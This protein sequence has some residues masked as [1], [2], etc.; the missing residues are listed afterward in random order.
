M[1]VLK[2]NV[3]IISEISQWGREGDVDY[4][5]KLTELNIL[6]QDKFIKEAKEL[7]NSYSLVKFYENTTCKRKR[8]DKK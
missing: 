1:A 7:L 5:F 8:K 6:Q 2:N 4:C 3:K